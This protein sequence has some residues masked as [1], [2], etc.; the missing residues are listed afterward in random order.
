MLT[1]R[2]STNPLA[3]NTCYNRGSDSRILMVHVHVSITLTKKNKKI[4]ALSWLLNTSIVM[5]LNLKEL[6][7]KMRKKKN[8]LDEIYVNLHPCTEVGPSI[9]AGRCILLHPSPSYLRLKTFRSTYQPMYFEWCF[10][11]IWV[12]NSF[13]P[14]FCPFD[15]ILHNVVMWWFV[16]R[17]I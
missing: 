17:S 2:A 16:C 14:L 4:Q 15:S 13:S 8:L 6:I 5:T 12:Y 3:D 9:D 1:V 10:L 7:S 11:Y